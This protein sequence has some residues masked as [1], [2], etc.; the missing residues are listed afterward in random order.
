LLLISVGEIISP[1]L[2]L[3]VPLVLLVKLV[4]LVLGIGV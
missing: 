4:K 2:V 1:L 3:L